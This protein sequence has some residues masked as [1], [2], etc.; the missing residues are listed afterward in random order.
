MPDPQKHDCAV[1]FCIDANFLQFS[2]FMIWQ[3]AHLN[4]HRRFDFVIASQ[5]DLVIPAWAKPYGIVLHRSGPYP[6]AAAG[7][8]FSGSM[9]TLF[10]IMLAREL[11][12]CYRRIIYMDSDMYVAGGDLG[13]LL[14]IDL[15]PHQIGAVLDCRY[16]YLVAPHDEEFK[17]AGLPNL[18][19]YNTGFQIIDTKAY[20]DQEVERRAFDICHNTKRPILKG[21][22]TLLNMALKGGFAQ[23]APCWNWQQDGLSPLLS[24]LYPVFHHHFIAARKPNLVVSRRLPVRFNQAYRDFM[25]LYAPDMLGAISDQPKPRQLRLQEHI[26]M[27]FDTFTAGR[28]TE[29]ITARFPDPYRAIL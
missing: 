7:A 17:A 2:L 11:G 15:G 26:R 6:E 8:R 23:L 28:I 29:A 18:P 12:D 14:D 4:P 20:R 24:H 27:V 25:A 21:D 19:Y 10:R 16:F 1:V 5:D 22:Q 9:S 3:I 13:R